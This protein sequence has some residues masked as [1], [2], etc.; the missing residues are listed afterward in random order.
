MP[1]T[2]SLPCSSDRMERGFSRRAS[3]D[4]TPTRWADMPRASFRSAGT[5]V[6]SAESIGTRVDGA[7]AIA[8]TATARAPSASIGVGVGEAVPRVY[9]GEFVVARSGFFARRS[10]SADSLDE[11]PE[12]AEEISDMDD[13]FSRESAKCRKFGVDGRGGGRSGSG[14]EISQRTMDESNATT[15]TSSRHWAMPT[16][17]PTSS[18]GRPELRGAGFAPTSKSFRDAQV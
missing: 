2:G 8:T 15:V 18:D 4:Y 10:P 7:G 1:R 5:R 9:S 16:D 13:S 6:A 17:S 14:R 11:L 12:D 3:D